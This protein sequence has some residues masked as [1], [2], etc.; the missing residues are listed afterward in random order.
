[1]PYKGLLPLQHLPIHIRPFTTDVRLHHSLQHGRPIEIA[2]IV[3]NV[4]I[5]T[6]IFPLFFVSLSALH[7]SKTQMPPRFLF[8]FNKARTK[9]G[10][11]PSRIKRLPPIFGKCRV[12]IS[13]KRTQ[14]EDH[15]P[16]IMVMIRIGTPEE[17][18][19][20]QSLWRSTVRWWRLEEVVKAGQKFK[21][22]S[23]ILNIAH[24]L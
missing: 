8:A 11:V 13:G 9:I 18:L 3:F 23:R 1:M 12:R 14:L 24:T 5:I 16:K 10:P 4:V 7:S 2:S 21:T 6:I 19:K 17:A 15:I 20:T 22:N